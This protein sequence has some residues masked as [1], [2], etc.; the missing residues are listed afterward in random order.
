MPLPW[1]LVRLNIFSC[2]YWKEHRFTC[3]FSLLNCMFVVPFPVGTVIF[4]LFLEY[5][6]FIFWT[7][8][9]LAP[10]VA[11]IFLLLLYFFL[12]CQFSYCFLLIT[13]S[14]VVLL[15]ESC[16]KGLP[17]FSV[18]K[19]IFQ[20]ILQFI[21]LFVLQIAFYFTYSLGFWT[22]LN[23]RSPPPKLIAEYPGIIYWMGIILSL[24]TTDENKH[25]LKV[26][27]MMSKFEG[28]L[29]IV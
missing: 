21:V 26:S 25:L 12:C 5:E 19:F 29:K 1:L 11:S 24:M 28:A 22:F 20:C 18:N 16:L 15:V 10:L 13:F 14:F 27:L 8:L 4:F 6:I 17:S 3:I 2:I 7:L 9:L 23:V